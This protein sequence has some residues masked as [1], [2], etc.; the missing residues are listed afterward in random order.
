MLNS[1]WSQDETKQIT[2]SKRHCGCCYRRQAHQAPL[3]LGFS[4]QEHLEWVAIS[5]CNAW[6]W[7]RSVV[8]N[9][10]RPHG[11]QPT[12]LLH[13]WDFPGKNTRVGCHCLLRSE[14]H[15]TPHICHSNPCFGCVKLR[16]LSLLWIWK[17]EVVTCLS[18]YTIVGAP[19]MKAL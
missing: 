7:S 14:A 9:S 18:S 2:Q 4:K 11:P 3:P 12:K 13:P 17:G 10:L 19:Q 1:I 16:R 5:F 15:S 8:S 6:K